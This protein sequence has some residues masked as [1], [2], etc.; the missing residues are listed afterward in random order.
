MK[1]AGG[2]QHIPRPDHWAHGE[3]ALWAE[4]SPPVSTAVAI[5]RLRDLLTV[6]PPQPLHPPTDPDE[7]PSSA[8]LIVLAE[9][10]NGA[11]VLLTRRPWHIRT[12]K[13]EFSFP[14][15]HLDPGE[16]FE[17]AA[18]REAYEEVGL[19]PESVEVIGRMDAMR[20]V[21]SR[22]WVVP[23]L[24]RIPRPVELVGHD[25]EVDR[26]FWVPLHDFTQSGTYHE[27]HWTRYDMPDGARRDISILFFHLDDETVWGLTA[28][29]MARVLEGVY[30]P[31]PHRPPPTFA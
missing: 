3:P 15:G 6:E 17:A 23:V 7:R 12:H 21:I 27:E 1:R 28:R 14:G 5:E 30:T 8:V 10:P 11:E 18:V 26:V 16:T 13:G 25:A 4:P 24:A 31:P 2:Q 22:T 29:M 20:L 19:D 9:G